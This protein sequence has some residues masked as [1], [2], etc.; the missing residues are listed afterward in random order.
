[1]PER[2]FE[3]LKVELKIAT[4]FGRVKEKKN[5]KFA[6]HTFDENL[7]IKLLLKNTF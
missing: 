5:L 2:I 4:N 7:K 3:A 6:K 1:L